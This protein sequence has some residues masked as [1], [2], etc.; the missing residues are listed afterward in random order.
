MS[1]A[2]DIV[3]NDNNQS[4]DIFATSVLSGETRRVTD[5]LDSQLDTIG[6][7]DYQLLDLN[8]TA[9]RLLFSSNLSN[10]SSSDSSI[11]QIYSLSLGSE[12]LKILSA[13]ADGTLGNVTT[14]ATATATARGYKYNQD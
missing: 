3:A 4:N 10:A 1:D 13:T 2:D 12:S 14:T 8:Q 5:F 6:V 7:V 11:Q 9:S